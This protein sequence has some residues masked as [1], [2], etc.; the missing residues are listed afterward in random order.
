MGAMLGMITLELFSDAFT[1]VVHVMYMSPCDISIW[2]SD[3]EIT[4]LK[5]WKREFLTIQQKFISY[6]F[7]QMGSVKE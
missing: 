5:C 6:V 2:E 7:H 3:I 4:K 1:K